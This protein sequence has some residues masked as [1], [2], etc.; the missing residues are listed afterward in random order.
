ME[1]TLTVLSQQQQQHPTTAS[2]AF[3]WPSSYSN[4]LAPEQPLVHRG[5]SF[6]VYSQP[7][8]LRYGWVHNREQEPV[9]LPADFVE[10]FRGKTVGFTGES[11]SAP[12]VCLYLLCHLKGGWR[13]CVCTARLHTLSARGGRGE[14]GG[15]STI[16]LRVEE[17]GGERGVKSEGG[18]WASDSCRVGGGGGVAHI[19]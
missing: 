4:A 15:E 7:V 11:V 12:C 9:P 10:R 5:E 18:R 8:S 3:A 19:G 2:S 13:V 16:L 14:R 17:G 6:E 1:P